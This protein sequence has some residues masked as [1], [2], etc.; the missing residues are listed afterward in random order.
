VIWRGHEINEDINWQVVGCYT[1]DLYCGAA[2]CDRKEKLNNLPYPFPDQYAGRTFTEC[3]RAAKRDGWILSQRDRRAI[4]PH[5]AKK[6][7]RTS[8]KAKVKNG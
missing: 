3:A 1:L 2:A 4:C 6:N 8:T 7:P 5:C